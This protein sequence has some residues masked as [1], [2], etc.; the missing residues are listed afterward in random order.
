MPLM[1]FEAGRLR[2]PVNKSKASYYPPSSASVATP[3]P[4]D[5]GQS[6]SSSSVFPRSSFSEISATAAAGQALLF[7][8]LSH[9]G[10][11]TCSK[12]QPIAENRSGACEVPENLD[13]VFSAGQLVRPA[14]ERQN[15]AEDAHRIHVRVKRLEAS[16]DY[17][18]IVS[19]WSFPE[20][21]K[22]SS[23]GVEIQSPELR[24][25]SRE[26]L[27]LGLSHSLGSS[28][29]GV[30][31]P[32]FIAAPLVKAKG[33]SHRRSATQVPDPPRNERR[34]HFRCWSD[35]DLKNDERKGP[36]DFSKLLKVLTRAAQGQPRVAQDSSR[37]EFFSGSA[38]PDEMLLEILQRLSIED[39]VSLCIATAKTNGLRIWMVAQLHFTAQLYGLMGTFSMAGTQ[40]QAASETLVRVQAAFREQSSAR[41]MF[42]EDV[43][44][45]EANQPRF[46][47]DLVIMF[48][49]EQRANHC[50]QVALNMMQVAMNRWNEV[51]DQKAIME[52]FVHSFTAKVGFVCSMATARMAALG[53]TAQQAT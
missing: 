49:A 50:Q 52:R 36:M 46:E 9:T 15:E 5:R 28:P 45:Y 39:V 31:T 29:C 25:E 11:G 4:V 21:P 34:Q 1:E 24:S 8:A 18:S 35:T 20:E 16:V 33:F 51:A 43:R 48:E 3:A 17:G 30:I 37:D 12:Q 32:T 23:T 44:L 53:H 7:G 38:S 26:A 6:S 47:L 19:A 13:V 10:A 22:A 27:G 2:R 40:A 14:P 42:L 41:E